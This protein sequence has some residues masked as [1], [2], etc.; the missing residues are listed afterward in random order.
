M[1]HSIHNVYA[2]L[3]VPDVEKALTFYEAAF[4]AREHYRLTEPGGRVGHAEMYLGSDVVMLAEEYPELGFTAPDPEHPA[5]YAIH[6]HVDNADRM[7]KTAVDA[8][9][10]AER[11]PEDQFYGERS[12][13]VRDPFGYRWLL[14]H[15]IE[16]VGIDDMQARYTRLFE[17]D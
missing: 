10:A 3:C 12:C 4:G 2:Y 14:G 1:S 6:L 17:Q 7:F 15:S 11:A 5:S 16:E 13:S 9:A 8:G